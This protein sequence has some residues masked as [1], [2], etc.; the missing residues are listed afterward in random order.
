[1]LNNGYNKMIDI[2]PAYIRDLTLSDIGSWAS[3][4]GIF[5]S[6]ITVITVLMLKKQ[7]IFR[8]RVEEHT[9][10]LK[11]IASN[12]SNYLNNYNN[13]DHQI[14]EEFALADVELRYIQRGAS[15]NLLKDIK[16]ARAGI[17]SFQ[18]RS[19]I[20]IEAIKPDQKTIRHINTKINIVVAELQNVKKELMVGK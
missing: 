5:I 13:E 18:L 2:M 6:G 15:G 8:S 7:F 14:H 16:N 9:D 19:F 1:M 4:L 10:K 17:R 12:I 11:K 20:K 3:I